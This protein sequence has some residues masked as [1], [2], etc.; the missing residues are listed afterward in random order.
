VDGRRSSRQGIIVTPKQEPSIKTFGLDMKI[1]LITEAAGGAVSVI[2]GW[3][4]PGEGG[5]FTAEKTMEM[6]REFAT[7]VPEEH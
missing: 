2:M 1:L 4:K 3:P 7:N 6:S 5:G